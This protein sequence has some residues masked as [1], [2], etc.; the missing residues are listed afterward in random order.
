MRRRFLAALA[1]ACGLRFKAAPPLPPGT[2][3]GA[4]D[5]LGHRLRKPDFPAPTETRQSRWPS[6]AAASAGCR[7]R[8]SWRARAATISCC[9]KWRARR[10]AIRAPARTRFRP[11]RWA[12]TTCRCRRARRAPRASC[13]PNSAC[14]GRPGCRASGLRRKVPVPCAAGTAVHQRLLAGGPVADAGRAGRGTGAIQAL[15]GPCRRT[16]PAARQCRTPRP[17]PCRWRCPAATRKLL[18]LDR[19][20]H[21]RLAADRG[22]HGAGPALAGRLRLPRRLRHRRRADL[23]LGR[24]ALLRLPRRRRPGADGAGR[25]RLAGARPGPCGA[26]PDTGPDALVFRVEQ[27][28][29]DIVCDVYLA[30]ENRSIRIVAAS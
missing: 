28:K 5:A 21:A 22:L 9:W 11:I 8:G 26:Q 10:A 12:P 20:N 25:Q 6:P 13:W 17:L 2:L 23:G 15:P 3:S 7:R 16:A 18:A 30:A 24:P 27:R 1:A 19:I 4:N 29:R 14:C